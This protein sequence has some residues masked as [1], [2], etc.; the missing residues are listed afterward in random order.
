MRAGPMEHARVDTVMMLG[1]GGKRFQGVEV[2]RKG[3]PVK[4]NET[5]C[6]APG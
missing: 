6:F 4:P 1:G 2:I 3:E 5:V